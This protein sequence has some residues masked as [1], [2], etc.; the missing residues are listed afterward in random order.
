M[1]PDNSQPSQ[2]P[3][4]VPLGGPV[5][6]PDSLIE[7]SSY[8]PSQLGSARLTVE[9]GITGGVLPL[10]LRGELGNPVVERAA[11]LYLAKYDDVAPQREFE[12]R[13]TPLV[14]EAARMHRSEM[15]ITND[16]EGVNEL[17]GAI[18]RALSLLDGGVITAHEAEEAITWPS[19]LPEIERRATARLLEPP[20][21]ESGSPRGDG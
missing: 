13:F 21:T 17:L 12:D 19:H 20:S 9:R 16:G 6:N 7:L 2:Q 11:L 8:L 4:Y 14:I 1:E 10:N 5:A 18:R 15:V 3:G